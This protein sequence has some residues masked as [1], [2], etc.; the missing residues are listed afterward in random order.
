MDKKLNEFHKRFTRFKKVTPQTKEKK[1]LKKKGLGKAGD[2]FNELCFICKERY[3]KGK[4]C[5]N[6][7][8]A[9]KFDYTKLRLTNEYDYESQEKEKQA[10]K[11]P[12][13]KKT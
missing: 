2:L 8:D 1:D 4:D 12:D 11:T 3:G 7:K 10:D 9:K 13:K 5:L 6:K